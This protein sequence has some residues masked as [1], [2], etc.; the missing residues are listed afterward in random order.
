MLKVKFY[1][2]PLSLVLILIFS[3]NCQGDQSMTT[4]REIKSTVITL[5][6]PTGLTMS[7]VEIPPGTFAMGSPD[8][9]IGHKP[10]ETQHQVTI[11]KTFYMGAC[12]VTQ[13]QYQKIMGVNP[14]L[15]VSNQMKLAGISPETSKQPVENVTWYD[16]VRFCNALSLNQGLQ[17][18]YSNQIGS[19]TIEDSDIVICDWTA[20][21]FRLPTEAEWEYACRAGTTSMYY[22]S[23]T[24]DEAE[25]MRYIWFGNNS[26]KSCNSDPSN[27]KNGPQPVGTKPPNAFGLYDMIG[28]VTEW[29]WDFYD[30]DYYSVSP[31]TDPRGSDS[32]TY[33]VSRGGSWFCALPLPFRCAHHV[34]RGPG[35]SDEVTGYRVVRQP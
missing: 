5:D 24:Y 32:E 20:T 10:S 13:E 26:N 16:A 28:N 27:T 11:S 17:P 35:N 31:K 1:V 22:W 12:E 18:C 29:C 33:R 6:A 3:W 19:S 8:T 34:K 21:G 25:M 9:E 14:S 4:T 30:S 2:L 23:D 15:F 7:L